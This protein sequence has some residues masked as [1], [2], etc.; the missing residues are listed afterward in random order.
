MSL[1]HEQVGKCNGRLIVPY[2]QSETCL[3]R[4]YSI[5]LV[6]ATK[7]WK[8]NSRQRCQQSATIYIHVMY[9]LLARI[10]ILSDKSGSSRFVVCGATAKARYPRRGL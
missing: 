6:S 9:I 1:G 5:P 2:S 10:F 3:S 8:K 7:L 4:S